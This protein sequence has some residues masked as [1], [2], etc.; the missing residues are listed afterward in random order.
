MSLLQDSMAAFGRQ[1]R[2]APAV[3]PAAPEPGPEKQLAQN[4]LIKTDVQLAPE[5]A[6]PEPEPEPDPELSCVGPSLGGGFQWVATHDM[7]VAPGGRLV[8]RRCL[9]EFPS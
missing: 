8:C 4:A 5:P 7:H 6:A 9:R 1:L 2:P 3:E